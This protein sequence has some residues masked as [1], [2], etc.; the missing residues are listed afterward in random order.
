[1]A[2]ESEIEDVVEE[3]TEEAAKVAL[4]PRRFTPPESVQVLE[5][6][7]GWAQGWITTIKQDMGAV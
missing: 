7:V 2:D 1:M 4:D 5:G 6:I 3:V